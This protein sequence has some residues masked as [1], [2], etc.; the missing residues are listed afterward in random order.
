MASRLPSREVLLSR[1]Y[2]LLALP[3]LVLVIVSAV[4]WGQGWWVHLSQL[5]GL[6]LIILPLQAPTG[7]WRSR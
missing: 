5:V 7:S 2:L 6:G 1:R 4:F 3:G